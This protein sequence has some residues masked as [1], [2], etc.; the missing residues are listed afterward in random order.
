MTAL[1]YYKYS[2]RGD[3]MLDATIRRG[4]DA[5]FCTSYMNEGERIRGAG[6]KLIP[7]DVSTK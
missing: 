1:E 6:A 3:G 4:T 2:L 5:R 7:W